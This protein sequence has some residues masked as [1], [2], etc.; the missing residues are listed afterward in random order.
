MSKD[1][2]RSSSE[3]SPEAFPG[4]RMTVVL[5]VLVLMLLGAVG[6][7]L[8]R[9]DGEDPIATSPATAR[10]TGSATTTTAVVV[11]RKSEI[12]SRLRE[13]LQVRDEALVARN[14]ELLTDI[15]TIDCKC[16]K[17]G[18]ALI[19]Q[20]LKENVVWKGVTTN[21]AIESTE[22][23]SSRLWIVVATVETPPVQI[24]TESG[25]LIRTVP[26]ERNLVR[27]ALAKVQNEDEWLLGHAS[28]L[29]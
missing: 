28:S 19:K 16:L 8:S 3:A 26:A 22:E 4:R 29:S 20:L 15:Y 12:E 21:I 6:V 24:E 5:L 7:V 18:R 14:S 11:S 23:V 1:D 10:A 9:T 25:K 13:I 27:F 2:P 17:D